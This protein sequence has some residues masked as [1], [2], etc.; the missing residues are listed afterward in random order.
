MPNLKINLK[1]QYCQI[2][3]QLKGEGNVHVK[4]ASANLAGKSSHGAFLVRE[5]LTGSESYAF[6][7]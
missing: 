5:W 4:T 6:L 2:L 7:E 3:A 1:E